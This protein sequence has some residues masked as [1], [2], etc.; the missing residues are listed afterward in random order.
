M[1]SM[2]YFSMG[3]EEYGPVVLEWTGCHDGVYREQT[4][5]RPLPP[6]AHSSVRRYALCFRAFLVHAQVWW[7]S[8]WLG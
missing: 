8:R 2:R 6:H 4:P 7:W 1:L 3:Y 5:S